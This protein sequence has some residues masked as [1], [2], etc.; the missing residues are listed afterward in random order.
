[1]KFAGPSDM[2]RRKRLQVKVGDMVRT[3]K[4]LQVIG[5]VV[6]ITGGIVTIKYT[7]ATGEIRE[8]YWSTLD[9]VPHAE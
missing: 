1:M 7:T 9:L 5:I 4:G 6:Y 2:A 8:S 3:T